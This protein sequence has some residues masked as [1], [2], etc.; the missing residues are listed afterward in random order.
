V[1][2]HPDGELRFRRPDG[3]LL[4]E[5]PLPLRYPPIPSR[6]C[7]RGTTRRAPHPR[8]DG[9]PRLAG[10]RLDVAGIDVMHPWRGRRD[11]HSKQVHR[12][13]QRDPDSYG[14]PRN[15]GIKLN[16]K[17]VGRP[18][19]CSCTAGPEEGLAGRIKRMLASG[20]TYELEPCNK[21]FAT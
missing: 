18:R 16:D 19:S 20:L 11:G 5:V 14:L 12:P 1:D 13:L 10:E 7:G 8:A 21:D 15:V 17:D 9:E 6:P 2:R 3:R 4:P